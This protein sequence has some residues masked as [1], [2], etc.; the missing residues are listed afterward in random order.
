[1]CVTGP[2]RMN[3]GCDL[4]LIEPRSEAFVADYFTEEE[5]EFIAA[6][7]SSDRLRMV[8]LLWSAKESALKTLREGLRLDTRSV[9][10]HLDC[11]LG[12]FDGWSR[13]HVSHDGRMFP[14]WWLYSGHFV[15]TV[16]SDVQLRSPRHLKI[17][18]GEGE[19]ATASIAVSASKEQL[20]PVAQCALWSAGR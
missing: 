6:A 13:L 11:S 9:V 15:R 7:S 18:T 12:D 14:G 19:D 16:V 1:L 3:L 8:A 5:Q 4:E 10:V 17:G 2:D 20:V